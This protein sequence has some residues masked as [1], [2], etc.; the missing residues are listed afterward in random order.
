MGEKLQFCN[1]LISHYESS[2]KLVSPDKLPTEF[3]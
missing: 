3:S 2:Q 1:S